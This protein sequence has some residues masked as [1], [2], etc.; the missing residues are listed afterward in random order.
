MPRLSMCTS[1]DMYLSALAAPR[2]FS[3]SKLSTETDR[4]GCGD[5]FKRLQLLKKWKQTFSEIPLFSCGRV[6]CNAWIN[7]IAF[8]LWRGTYQIKPSLSVVLTLYRRKPDRTSNANLSGSQF[9]ANRRETLMKLC[10]KTYVP[11]R[12]VHLFEWNCTKSRPTVVTREN[13]ST[14]RK[15]TNIWAIFFNLKGGQF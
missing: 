5:I 14:V 4:E 15:I 7:S 1:Q 3:L 9:I 11:T 8:P 12:L 2:C 10:R 13:L 6:C